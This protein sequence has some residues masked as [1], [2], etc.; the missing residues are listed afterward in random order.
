[1]QLAG[2]DDPSKAVLRLFISTFARYMASR[3]LNSVFIERICNIT[4]GVNDDAGKIFSS[5]LF[6]RIKNRH[7]ESRLRRIGLCV[8]RRHSKH[9]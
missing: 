7:V 4:A 9:L 1:M 6:P 5:P 3:T 2:L 8:W